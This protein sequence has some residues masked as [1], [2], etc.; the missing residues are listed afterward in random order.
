MRLKS[1]LLQLSENKSKFESKDQKVG[2]GGG[3]GGSC[4]SLNEIVSESHSQASRGHRAEG[5]KRMSE[6]ELKKRRYQ[7]NF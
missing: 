3:G 1:P 4:G 5:N 7:I 2:G 6:K